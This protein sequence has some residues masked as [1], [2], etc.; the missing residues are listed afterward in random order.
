M[1][2]RTS[3]PSHRQNLSF[4]PPSFPVCTQTHT[5]IMAPNKTSFYVKHEVSTREHSTAKHRNSK[6]SYVCLHVQTIQL[7]LSLKKDVSADTIALGAA[8]TC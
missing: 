1:C 3:L 8:W 7:S 5:H 2:Y 4:L 6:R